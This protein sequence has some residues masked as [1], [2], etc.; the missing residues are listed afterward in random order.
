MTTKARRGNRIAAS[1]QRRMSPSRATSDTGATI[2]DRSSLDYDAIRQACEPIGRWW[3]QT[4]ASGTA[5]PDRLSRAVKRAKLLGPLPGTLG[6][7][8][9]YILAG[10]PDLDY[11]RVKAAFDHVS[12]AGTAGPN[13]SDLDHPGVPEP[14]GA[15]GAVQ[16]AFEMPSILPM[17]RR[18]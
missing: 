7:A 3:E 8:L 11:P 9:S 10:C 14:Q 13:R 4:Q 18:R 5:D 6:A 2:R 12:A 17:G 1:S 15:Q 16:L